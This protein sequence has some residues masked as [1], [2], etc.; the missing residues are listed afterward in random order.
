MIRPI[1]YALQARKQY[2]IDGDKK[3]LIET[4]WNEAL[5]RADLYSDIINIVKKATQSLIHLTKNMGDDTWINGKDILKKLSIKGYKQNRNYGLWPWLDDTG[6]GV[7]KVRGQFPNT[8]YRIKR[9]F[10]DTLCEI[11]E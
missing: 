7:I 1:I 10:F 5:T 9:E 4:V 2:D 6:A 8:S 3:K 11:I